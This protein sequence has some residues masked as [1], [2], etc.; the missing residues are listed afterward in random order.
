[1]NTD[2]SRATYRW[3][4]SGRVQGVAFRWFVLT[5]ARPLGVAGWARNLP[6][7]RVDVVGQANPEM[8]GILEGKLRKGPPS[9]HVQ[10]VEKTDITSEVD[11]LNSFKIR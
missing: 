1:M 5:A 8:L 9:S 7:G 2:D 11:G 10:S 4:V 6:D 3:L